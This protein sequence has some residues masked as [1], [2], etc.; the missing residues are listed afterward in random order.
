MSYFIEY[1]MKDIDKQ[2]EIRTLYQQRL[3]SCFQ[4][5]PLKEVLISIK[6]YYLRGISVFKLGSH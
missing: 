3:K 6:V 1:H 4:W 2:M 5:Q